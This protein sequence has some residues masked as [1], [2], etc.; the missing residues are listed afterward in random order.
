MALKSLTLTTLIVTYVCTFVALVFI[1][2][3]FLCR[4]MRGEKF[5]LFHDDVWMGV[6]LVPLLLR[7][8]ISHAVIVNGTSTTKITTPLSNDAVERRVLGSKLV[9]VTRVLYPAL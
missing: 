3:R 9:L 6:A 4:R 1:L 7:L 2:I 8:G 5:M